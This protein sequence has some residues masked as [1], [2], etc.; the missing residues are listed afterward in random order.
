MA[1]RIKWTGLTPKQKAKATKTYKFL[2]GEGKSTNYARRIARAEAS[3]K[4]RQQSRGHKEHEHIERKEREIAE[5]GVSGSQLKSIRSFLNRFNPGWDTGDG[6]KGVPTE[7]DL[8]EFVQA[9]DWEAFGQYR[10]TW[11][12]YRRRWLK[13]HAA[14]ELDHAGGLG[15]SLEEITAQAGV[16]PE[17]DTPWL[18]YH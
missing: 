14:K 12:A 15:Y 17:G 5:Q 11:D 3:G 2:V 13:A 9:R 16:M 8:V 6:H 1:S 18:Y 10:T 4:T 7:E